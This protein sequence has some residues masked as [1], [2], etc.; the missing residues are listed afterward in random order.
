MNA[1]IFNEIVSITHHDYSGSEDKRG[2][3]NPEKYKCQIALLEERNELTPEAF[4]N[5]VQ[6]YLL[7]FKDRHMYFKLTGSKEHKVHDNGFQVKRFGDKLYITHVSK[8][9]R[10]NI[11]DIILSLD[12]KPIS[13]L[14]R[15]HKRELI[16]D[17]A[18]RENWKQVIQKYSNCEVKEING[19]I[20]M[21]DLKQYEKSKYVPQH[22]VQKVNNDTLLMTLSDFS[23]LTAI[24]DLIADVE[25]DLQT[26]P[27]LIVDVRENGG[28]S[29]AAYKELMPYLFPE[30]S[31]HV[32]FEDS[33]HSYHCTRRNFELT[34]KYL[35]QF[36]EEVQ[37]KE[38]KEHLHMFLVKFEENVGNGFKILFEETP[39]M[40]IEGKKFPQQVVVLTD[41]NCGS[42]GEDF[43]ESCKK[44]SKATVIGR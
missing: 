39:S 43:V 22:T 6:D 41:V 44:S 28:G 31:T 40:T 35:G 34:K 25:E 23:S 36:M 3:D 21:I 7:D 1:K 2:W 29:D 30:G 18:E 37:D 8:E 33:M 10:V 42:A 20:K 17:V 32:T 5:L 19:D 16:E 15:K 11:G 4:T 12:N 26:V 24:P 13:E 14:A 9:E 27:N 38:L